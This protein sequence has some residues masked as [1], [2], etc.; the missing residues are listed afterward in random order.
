MTPSEH[1]AVITRCREVQRRI[2]EA[3]D[4]SSRRPD[5]VRLIGAGKRQDL[6]RLRAAYEAGLRAFGENQV[7][8]AI[9]HG[10]ELAD[11][12]DWH[13]IGPLQSNKARSAAAFFSTIQSIDR[14][15]IAR[16]LE[17]QA[18][19]LG[20]TLDAFLEVNLG[21]EPT[22]H[23]FAPSALEEGLDDLADL[24]NIRIVGLMA[25]P[26]MAESPEQSRRWFAELRRLRDRFFSLPS[27]NGRP[28][29]LSMGMS[30][31]FEIAIEEGATHV[32]VG[33]ALFGA[34]AS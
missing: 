20:R 11:D 25:I 17:R 14:I 7:Q 5:E 30:A 13:L 8:E 21:G 23:G 28:G 27:W 16:V 1:D 24:E 29:Y 34:R 6:E 15:K 12:I 32:R 3:C 2:V 26:P 4:R 31:D 9:V 10:A 22:K 18:T 19:R 33:T